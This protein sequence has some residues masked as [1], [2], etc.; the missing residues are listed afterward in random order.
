MGL[1]PSIAKAIKGHSCERLVQQTKN[2]FDIQG[3]GFGIADFKVEVGNFSNKIERFYEV[4]DTMVSLDNTQYLL[5]TTMHQDFTDDKLR[6]TCNRIRLQI[7][8]A[9]NQLQSLLNSAARN[10]SDE[11][12]Q[13]LEEWVIYMNDLS[14][15]SIESIASSPA[16]TEKNQVVD[17]GPSGGYSGGSW[18]DALNPANWFVRRP[19]ATAPHIASPPPP[20]ST[21]SLDKVLDRTMSYQEIEEDEM[22]DALKILS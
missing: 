22:R 15:N 14:K 4:T 2:E 9:F 12:N 11:I 8:I 21:E 13:K 10:P 20:K 19:K 3:V 18:L 5:C 7:V 17:K 1:L 6:D 16:H